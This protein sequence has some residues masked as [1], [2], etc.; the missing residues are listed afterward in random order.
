MRAGMQGSRP[1]G[2][3]RGGQSIENLK[4]PGA[5]LMTCKGSP[6]GRAYQLFRHEPSASSQ[7]R[8]RYKDLI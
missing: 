5:M 8:L 3:V 2:G 6:D 1:V 4:A 7:G